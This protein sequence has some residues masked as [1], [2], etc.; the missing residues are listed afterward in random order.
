MSFNGNTRVKIPAILHLCKLG[1]NYISLTK[2]KRDESTNIFTDVFAESIVHINPEMDESN[3][4][5]V[6]EDVSL[7]DALNGFVLENGNSSGK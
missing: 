2:A 4:K 6:F 1:Y 7:A 5:R 3:F